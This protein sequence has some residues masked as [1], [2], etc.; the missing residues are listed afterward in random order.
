L[1]TGQEFGTGAGNR[2]ERAGRAYLPEALRRLL[3]RI[4]RTGFEP[5]LGGLAEPSPAHAP[6]VPESGQLLARSYSNQVG[7]R[8]YKLY[9]PS[10]YRG[11]PL[12]LI[13][14]LHAAPN[15]PMTSPPA[16]A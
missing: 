3:D 15:P 5:G 8:A 7:T 6:D 10:G 16:R 1:R 13:V 4:P 9:V 11:E 14:M 12:P 2:D